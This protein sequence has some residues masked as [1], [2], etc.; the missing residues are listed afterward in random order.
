MNANNQGKASILLA[1]AMAI[2]VTF[3]SL[4]AQAVPPMGGVPSVRAPARGGGFDWQGFVGGL[5][6]AMS[7]QPSARPGYRPYRPG[8][9][10][11]ARPGHTVP[12]RPGY[13]VPYLPTQPSYTPEYSQPAAPPAVAVPANV[14]RVQVEVPKQASPMEG[15]I[16]E[17]STREAICYSKE[18]AESINA[19]L[20]SALDSLRKDG[21]EVEPIQKQSDTLRQMM[22]RGAS[23]RDMEDAL[24]KLLQGDTS[25]LPSQI[26]QEFQRIAELIA[27]RDAFL[28]VGSAGPRARTGPLPLAAIPVGVVWILFDPSLAAGTGLIVNEIVL[29]VGTGGVGELHV[30]QESAAAA[31]GLPVAPGEPV[32]DSDEAEAASFKDAIVIINRADAGTAVNY[33]LNGR[34]P[35]EIEPGHR[36]KLPADQRWSIEFDRGNARGSAR[37]ELSPGV[38]E[39]RVV[40][41]HWELFRVPFEIT[42]DNREG[43]QDFQYLV[44]DKVMTAKAGEIKKHSSEAPVVVKFDRGEGPEHAA[45]KNLNKSGTYKVAVNTQTNLLDLY[46]VA[47]PDKGGPPES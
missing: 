38:Y 15:R 4:P 20:M 16:S 33:V 42:I 19:R 26:I 24:K 14:V 3:Q 41:G 18:L 13:T 45:L 9:T 25:K 30:V 31:F 29:V 10:V 37:Y 6:R 12:Y 40:E 5:S 44:E 2:V 35:F 47:P 17:V 7:E 46:A 39:F 22:A 32:L 34:H 27:V 21:V 23:L 43:S 1:T 28:I 11:P 8:Y 36:Q